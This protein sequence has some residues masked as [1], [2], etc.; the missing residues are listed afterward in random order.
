MH[1]IRTVYEKGVLTIAAVRFSVPLTSQWNGGGALD[2]L[3]KFEAFVE[4]WKEWNT[5][6][7]QLAEIEA[8]VDEATARTKDEASSD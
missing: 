7:E 5:P 6:E 3:E 4:C 8:A 2:F 1:E